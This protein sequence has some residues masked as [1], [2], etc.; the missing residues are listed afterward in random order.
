MRSLVVVLLLVA[1]LAGCATSS[2]PSATSTTPSVASSTPVTSTPATATTA[3]PSAPATTAPA[4]GGSALGVV[5]DETYDY[6][7]H[8]GNETSRTFEVPREAKKITFFVESGGPPAD[9]SF[10]SAVMD[11][12]APHTTSP[13]FAELPGQ[14]ARNYTQEQTAGEGFW[15]TWKIV[16]AGQ[17]KTSI[18]VRVT[19][20]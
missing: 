13:M 2:P 15:G 20:S 14:Q 18:H 9:Q 1:A 3:T 4:T 5:F 10:Q 17:G 12:Y 6:A 16:F 19:L 11:V 7:M 8:G